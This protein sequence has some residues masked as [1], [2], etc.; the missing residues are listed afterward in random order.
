MATSARTTG[1]SF[2]AEGLHLSTDGFKELP[3]AEDTGFYRN[4]WMF[5]GS[6]VIEPDAKVRNELR[7]KLTYSDEVSNETYLGLSD[8]DFEDDPLQRYAASALDRMRNYRTAI[9]ATHVMDPSDEI[10]LTTNVYRHDYYRI[11][12]KANHFRGAQLF[13]VLTN[14]DEAGNDTYVD[15]LRGETDSL[16]ESGPDRLYIGPNEREFV[17]QGVESRLRWDAETGPISHR[18]EY[19]VRLHHDR[20]DRR[21]SEDAFV[22]EGGE[23]FP[24]GTPTVVTAFNQAWTYALAGHAT[25]A[26]TWRALT[27][28]PG[29]RVEAIRSGALD[30]ISGNENLRWAHAVLPGLGLYYGLTDQLGLLAGAYRG[31]SPPAPGSSPDIDPELSWNYEAG[32]RYTRGPARAELI[33]FYNDYEN[34]TDLCTFSTG[35]ADEELDQQF[36]A[37]H[38]RIYGFEA[39]TDYDIP[40]GASLKL[41]V[42]AAYTFTQTEFLETFRSEDPI[43]GDVERGDEMPYVPKHQLSAALGLEHERAGG[44]VSATYVAAMREQAGDEALSDV[45]ATD[46]QLTFDVALY[47]RAMKAIELYAIARNLL[48]SDF[49]VSRRPYGARPNAPLFVHVGVKADL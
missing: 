12:R 30:R 44:N 1:K 11:W 40:L 16:P 5:K 37:G 10:K 29:L 9:V 6:Y 8:E 38:A 32:A 27:V 39:F 24:E 2:L 35:C 4:D 48:D 41:P 7:I 21:H 33:G 13:D 26:M 17:S 42:T 28:T 14:P 31:F 20:I 3:G 46:E 25:N 49:I 19:G 45:L 15:L 23:L 36:D 47:Y 43:F 34:L 18:M 22:F